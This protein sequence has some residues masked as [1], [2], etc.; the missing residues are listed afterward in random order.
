MS[1]Y[2]DPWHYANY[3]GIGFT[4]I[5]E[6]HMNFG[7]IGVIGVMF[8]LGWVLSHLYTNAIMKS[9][10]G[11]WVIYFVVAANTLFAIRQDVSSILRP[12]WGVVFVWMLVVGIRLLLRRRQPKQVMVTS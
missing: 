2:T 4:L 6:A 3:Q 7:L 9:D 5:S 8:L 12:A 1:K 10:I 11:S